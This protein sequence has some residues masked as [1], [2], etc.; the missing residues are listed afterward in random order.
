M[1]LI[2]A[3]ALLCQIHGA[4]NGG[5]IDYAIKKQKKCQKELSKC[6]FKRGH[7]YR[8]R[9]VLECVKDR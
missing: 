8:V 5:N 6:V 2:T 7:P 3:I 9:E 1:E 4:S